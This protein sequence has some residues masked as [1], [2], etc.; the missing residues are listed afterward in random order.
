[1]T[2]EEKRRLITYLNTKLDDVCRNGE[3]VHNGCREAL[4]LIEIVRRTSTE[5]AV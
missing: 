5:P 2:D 4:E 3:P 1:M